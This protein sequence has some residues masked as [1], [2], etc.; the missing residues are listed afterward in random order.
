MEQFLQMVRKHIQDEDPIV[1]AFIRFMTNEFPYIPSELVNEQLEK[2]L[3]VD[4]T[5]LI[6]TLPNNIESLD[7]RSIPILV[8]LLN[9]APRLQKPLLYKY[10]GKIRTKL[11]V[12]H[13]DQ[14]EKHVKADFIQ[15]CRTI[16]E[17]DEKALWEMYIDLVDEL[18]YGEGYSHQLYNMAKRVQTQLIEK[19]YYNAQ[20]VAAILRE[21]LQE[22]YFS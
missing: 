10:V 4:S 19:G 13:A 2:V 6:S 8:Q 22:D 9:T 17:A 14:F 7:E 18:E 21:E 5:K 1:R 15:T 16:L 12:Q 20:K 11:L 3:Q